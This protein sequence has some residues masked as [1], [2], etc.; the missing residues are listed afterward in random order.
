MPF[1]RETIPAE[2]LDRLSEQLPNVFE[3]MVHF[4][5]DNPKAEFLAEDQKIQ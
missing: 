2:V 1:S 4:N 5:Q 3:L